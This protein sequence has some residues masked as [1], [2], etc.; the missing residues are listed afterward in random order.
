MEVWAFR[1]KASEGLQK[2][3]SMV[4]CK[5]RL[6]CEFFRQG[7]SALCV[8]SPWWGNAPA[9]RLRCTE[10]TAQPS[11]HSCH[12]SLVGFSSGLCAV[13]AGHFFGVADPAA[14]IPGVAGVA[15]QDAHGAQM[16]QPSAA[17]TFIVKDAPSN[18][19]RGHGYRGPRPRSCPRWSRI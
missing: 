10:A 8:E 2:E 4:F 14:P 15:I 12:R 13:P 18:G 5:K 11:R 17:G 16:Q 19:C 3:R 6:C 9:L 7:D 1:L